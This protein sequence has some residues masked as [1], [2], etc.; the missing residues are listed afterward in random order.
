MADYYSPFSCILNVKTVSNVRKALRLFREPHR[1]SPPEALP[2]PWAE[3]DGDEMDRSSLFEVE[4]SPRAGH[5]WLH[6]GGYGSPKYV[7]SFVLACA[8]EFGLTG[9]WGFRWALTCSD[10]RLDGFGG[11]ATV[12]DL[13]ARTTL[14]SVDCHEWLEDRLNPDAELPQPSC[15]AD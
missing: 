13:G 1:W 15:L 4:A 12:L 14:A 7:P 8:E 6:D 5:L 2:E 10:G 11:G 9:R 3:C